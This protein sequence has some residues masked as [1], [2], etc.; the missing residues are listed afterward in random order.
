MLDRQPAPSP[1]DG[2]R[3]RADAPTRRCPPP[4]PRPPGSS[5]CPT[6]GS[7]PSGDPA[8]VA[9]ARES[10][11]LAFVAALQH[12][13]PKQRAVLILREV[14][15]WKA[16][17]VAELLDTTVASVNSALQRARATLARRHADDDAAVGA[18]ATR[19]S[20]RCWRATSTPSS[21]T[22]WTR[23][24]RSCART[25]RGT[26]RRTTCG[27]RPTRTSSPGA[28]ARASA[29]ADSRLV[30]TMANGSPAFGQ[31]KP[32]G[33]PGVWTAVV[34][35]GARDLRRT[36]SA[37]SPS[38]WTPRGSSRRSGCPSP[39]RPEPSAHGTACAR[40]QRSSSSRSSVDASDRR[41]SQPSRRAARHARAS[42]SIVHRSGL[43]S[44]P[45]SNTTTSAWPPS[46]LDAHAIG[47]Q[48]KVGAVDHEADSLGRMV[49]CDQDQ[50]S[51]RGL[52]PQTRRGSE[53][54]RRRGPG[55]MRFPRSR[56]STI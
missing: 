11:R 15:R 35:P 31:Y 45:T 53:T 9:L 2:P 44:A 13:P 42:A 40:P 50:T 25:R 34:A 33:E 28:W 41:S 12:L 38:S 21:G 16:D 49:G 5:R 51:F 23:S 22:T 1:P 37:G 26:C 46:K 29:A 27:S 20:G 30:P 8:E 56:R 6:V 24:P 47:Q 54:H 52:D 4:F 48:W 3:A 14:L 36:G 17:E 19:S 7:C 32:S 43:M 55:P 39:S 18:G 10:I